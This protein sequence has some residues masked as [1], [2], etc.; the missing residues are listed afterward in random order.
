MV[1]S[2]VQ[3]VR[4][5]PTLFQQRDSPRTHSHDRGPRTHSPLC[6]HFIRVIEAS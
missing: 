1:M 5:V 6:H 2:H 3:N 4:V